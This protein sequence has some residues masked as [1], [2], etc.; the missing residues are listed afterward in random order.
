VP[1]AK[2]RGAGTVSQPGPS[3]PGAGLFQTGDNIVNTLRTICLCCCLAVAAPV[4]AYNGLRDEN[5]FVEAMLR[6]MEV[7]GLIDRSRL[8]LSVPYVPGYSPS[9]GGMAPMYGLGGLGGLGTLGTL[10]GVGGLSGLG[11]VPGMGGL[12]SLGAMPGLGGVPGM[13]GLPGMGGVPGM[14][15]LS[16]LGAMPGSLMAP[17]AGLS[18]GALGGWPIAGM[19]GLGAQQ[20]QQW[21]GARSAPNAALEGIWELTNGGVVII[22]GDRAR[23]YLSRDRYQ[24]FVIAYDQQQLSWAPLRGGSVSRY[25]YQVRDGRMV[26]QDKDGNYLLLRRRR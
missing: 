12:S 18:Q 22:R 5:P 13:T 14:G 11:G 10:P 21:P 1:Y 19:Q 25:R 26:M 16:S 15:G 7:F 4:A 23:L 9:M 2:P 8:P 17:G 6:M 24:D 3:T 20:W